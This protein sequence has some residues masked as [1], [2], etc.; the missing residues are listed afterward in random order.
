S[1]RVFLGFCI[2][3]RGSCSERCCGSRSRRCFPNFASV[4]SR[5]WSRR[6]HPMIRLFINGLAASAGGGLTYLC[7]VIP[8]LA[9]RADAETT[10]AFSSAM[11]HDFDGLAN[12]SFVESPESGGAAGR[13][14][15]EQTALP[16]L[17][18]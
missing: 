5:F 15:R 13:F 8:H 1:L 12:I 18:R 10:V 7:N 4:P 9:R 14:V 2:S 3:T 6:A 11:H 17:I 16:G